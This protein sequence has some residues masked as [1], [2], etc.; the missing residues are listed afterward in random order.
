MTTAK[1][2]YSRDACQFHAST[3]SG[4]IRAIDILLNESSI[5]P[6]PAADSAVALMRVAVSQSVELEDM[7]ES[8]HA[9]DAEKAQ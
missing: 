5:A 1:Q 6:S 8:I 2:T 7:L 9:P 3:L 4:V